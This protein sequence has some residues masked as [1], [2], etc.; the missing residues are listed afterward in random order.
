MN[1][2]TAPAPLYRLINSDT[3][4][5]LLAAE[6]LHGFFGTS[7]QRQTSEVIFTGVSCAPKIPKGEVDDIELHVVDFRGEVIGSYYIG[8]V[9]LK[10]SSEGH[11]TASFYGYSCP[12]PL[13]GDMWRRWASDRPLGMGEWA[14]YPVEAH[15]SWLHVV[16]TAWFESG[17]GAARYE[18]TESIA[19]DGGMML[20]RSGLY[21]A[22]GEAFNGVGGYF[23]SS[24]DG[25][26]DCLSASRNSM[27]VRVTWRNS[28]VS[29]NRLGS[30]FF[31]SV[32]TLMQEYDIEVVLL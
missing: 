17:R 27:P 11:V 10:G 5:V 21:C 8:R 25:L 26:A 20:D 6:D 16:Q 18:S 4:D 22:V 2:K 31:I 30:D 3:L 19:I 32:V 28:T 14:S 23:G 1:Y 9:Q 7:A 29:K 12:F 15:A 24:L 13:A